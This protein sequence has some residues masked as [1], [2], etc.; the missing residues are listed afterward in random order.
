MN[1]IARP[2]EYIDLHEVVSMLGVSSTTVRNWIK[3]NYLTL[4]ET[5]DNKLAFNSSQIKE[6]K[7]KI[8]SGEVNRLNKRANK[9]S[10]SSTF[11]PN[12][13]ADS[14][15]VLELVQGI[16]D[17][18]KYNKLQ[19]D[20]VLLM[21]AINLLKSGNLVSYKNLSNFTEL[22]FKNDI[23]QNE[24][25]WWLKRIK[26]TSLDEHYLK[27]LDISIPRV[28]DFLGLVYQSLTTEGNKSEGGSYY[29]PKNVV[30]EIIDS[31]VEK[32]SFVLDPCCG[33]GQFILSVAKKVSDPAKIWG[34]DIDEEAVMLARLNLIL[35]FSNIEFEPHIYCK[36]TL[37]NVDIANSLSKYNMPK[38][39]VIIT[40]PPWGVHFSKDESIYLKELF[41][42]IKSGESFAYFIKKGLQMLKE[43]GILSFVLP[44]S[45]LNIKTHKDIREILLDKTSIKKVKYLSRVFKN[46]F[47]PV[48]RL[49]VVNRIP[50]LSNKIIAEKDSVIYE[51]EQDRLKNN[52]DYIFNVFTD[53]TDISLFGKVYG[54]KYKTLK[55]NAEWALGIVTGDNKKHLLSERGKNNEPILTGK[56]VKKFT[57]VVAKNFIRFNPKNFQQ[58]APEYKYRVAEKLIY[59]FISKELVFSYDNKQ[60]L[61]LNS[62]NILIPM[63]RDYPIKTILALFNSSL[64]QFIY[65]KKF[66]SLKILKGD[67]EQLPLPILEQ[68]K[69]KKIKQL[70]NGLLDN[71]KATESRK[72]EY[73][74]L[75]NYIMELFNLAKNEK[76]YIKK[77]IKVS[78]NLLNNI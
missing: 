31:Y 46:V 32:N 60:T 68:K 6:L 39:D 26:D 43:G 52:S 61:T 14:Q 72:E 15:E 57:T 5:P 30:D 40:N 76:E 73:D 71:T 74:V 42:E 34:F 25:G 28:A 35:H 69:H 20:K 59:K 24:I 65:Q 9:K 45:I 22:Y 47:T 64:Y 1:T 18:Y 50:H 41:S 11:I 67:I 56:D 48:I 16:V 4:R 7:R 75:D 10:S 17:S 53:A 70:V 2:S 78:D 62:A 66:G 37:T 19:K 58:V 23:I 77:S 13:Y 36:N 27:L 8:A 3:Y 54:V 33:T 38:F 21:L 55:D 12:E 63:V 51:I 29:T 49:D 44:E